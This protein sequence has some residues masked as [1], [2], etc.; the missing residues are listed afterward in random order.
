V[1]H[2]KCAN[3]YSK[4]ILDCWSEEDSG[5]ED[6]AAGKA[7]GDLGILDPLSEPGVVGFKVDAAVIRV[8]KVDVENFV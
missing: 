5:L 1:G 7:E 3:T 8:S 2:Y 6:A 4:V